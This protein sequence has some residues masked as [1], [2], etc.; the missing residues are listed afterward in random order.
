MSRVRLRASW[1]WRTVAGPSKAQSWSMI[2]RSSSPRR[3]RPTTPRIIPTTGS[4]TMRRRYLR[5][6][7]VDESIGQGRADGR[8]G[9]GAVAVR[10]HHRRALLLRA[11]HDL[12]GLPRRDHGDHLAAHP[13]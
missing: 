3:V 7:V 9:T 4:T 1:T 6:A 13:Q 10:H 12:D 8:T 5:R 11:V 2:T